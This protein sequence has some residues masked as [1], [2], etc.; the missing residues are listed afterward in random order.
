MSGPPVDMPNLDDTV[1]KLPED[2]RR[3][4]ATTASNNLWAFN[5]GVLGFRDITPG[6]HGPLCAFHDENPAKYKLTLIPRGHLKTS[7]ITIGKNL[8]KVVRNPEIRLLI[9]NETSTNAERFLAA[10]KGIAESNR[11]FRALYSHVLPRGSRP[12]RWSQQELL[13]HREG[14]YPE[15]TID[16]IGMTG[17]YTSRHYNHLSIDDPIS[18]E[19]AKSKLVMDDVINRVSK[20]FSLMVNPEDDTADI[21][22]TR[23]AF[24]DVYT[25]V[26]QWLGDNLAKFIRAA[27]EDG[28]PIWKERFTLEKLALIRDDPHMGEY[29]FSCLYMNNP[30]NPDV[31]DFNVQDLRFWRW[32]ADEEHIVLYDKNGVAT[33]V[34][35]LAK[36]DITITVDV[37]YGEKLTT[38]RD[39][40]V[41]VGCT[42]DGD[43]I[44]LDAWAKR[45]NPLEVV[46]HLIH[47][48][49][50]FQPR[51]I[52]VQKVGY[53]MSLKWFLQAA[54]EREGVYAN[55]VPVRPGGPGKT[56]IRGLQPVAATGHLY[57]LPTQHVLRQEL[58]EYPL[59]QYDDVGDAL[60]LQLQLWRGLLSPERMK[61]YRE[62]EKRILRDTVDY[63]Q[64]VPG[65]SISLVDQMVPD[66][67]GNMPS[68]DD[69]GIDPEDGRYGEIRDYIIGE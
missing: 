42:E 28:E 44:V 55:V 37:R 34:V 30:R 59:G 21:T 68:L 9:A 32:A 25:Y 3:D 31:Q 43:A 4:L 1:T 19:A 62:F 41:A 40:I 11:V 27:I 67:R 36:L 65:N 8:Q 52:G 48:I 60:A 2:I 53:E 38:D 63:G 13:F 66:D 24:Y 56:H 18:E 14:N 17:A 20:L 57:I 49:K 69:L 61:R 22:G 47:L 29:M 10:I 12:N 33:K 51:C 50:R 15:P 39:A 58:A 16:T 45:G 46:S 35:E 23:W 5:K 54:C 7:C 64:R 6:C 26:M